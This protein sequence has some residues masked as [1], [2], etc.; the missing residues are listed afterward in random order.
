MLSGVKEAA[1]R[2]MAGQSAGARLACVEAA[3]NVTTGTDPSG[4]AGLGGGEEG[5]RK[6]RGR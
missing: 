1:E 6:N 5:G 4:S 3:R 2:R